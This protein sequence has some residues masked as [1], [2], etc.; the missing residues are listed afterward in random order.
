MVILPPLPIHPRLDYTSIM[1]E[2][3]VD[4]A[5]RSIE[6]GLAVILAFCLFCGVLGAIGELIKWGTLLRP[7]C[8]D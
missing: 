6:K 1:K 2:H 8:G 4:S 3:P 5:I 7:C